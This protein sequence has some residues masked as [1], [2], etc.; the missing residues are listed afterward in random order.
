MPLKMPLIKKYVTYF[1]WLLI[2]RFDI[3]AFGIGFDLNSLQGYSDLHGM[4]E[5]TCRAHMRTLRSD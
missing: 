4:V 5:S 2:S 3:S 1:Y